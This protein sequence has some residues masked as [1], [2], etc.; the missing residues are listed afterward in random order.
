M[1]L[2]IF[3]S[4]RA[5]PNLGAV[6]TIEVATCSDLAQRWHDLM[7]I[8]AGEIAAGTATIEEVGRVI[9]ETYLDVAS[10]QKTKTEKLGIANALAL[11]NP[12]PIT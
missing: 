8:G 2:H 9:F 12:A 7:D 11:F 1:N 5:P 10:G 4:D 6:P 3:T